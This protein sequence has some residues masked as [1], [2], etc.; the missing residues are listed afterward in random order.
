MTISDITTADSTEA[1]ASETTAADPVALPRLKGDKAKPK[2]RMARASGLSVL[3][4]VGAGDLDAPAK[5]IRAKRAKAPA[6]APRANK[7]AAVLALL[8]RPE[9][10]SRAE[11]EE[12]TG[13]QP[14]T[15]RAFLSGLRKKGL[16]VAREEIYPGASVYRIAPAD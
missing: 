2:K 14:H 15:L 9:G 10:A 5:A 6:E 1:P 8:E 12:F 11:L 7:G 13:W 16:N 4:A 3:A